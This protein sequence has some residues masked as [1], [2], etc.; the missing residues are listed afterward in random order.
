MAKHAV[1]TVLEQSG[2]RFDLCDIQIIAA[3]D[4]APE[5]FVCDAPAPCAIS[6]SHAAG[7]ALCEVTEAGHSPGCD[8]EVVEA[9]NRTFLA[10]YFVEEEASFVESLSPTARAV[11]ATLIWSAKESAL[12]SLREGLRRDTRS[13]IVRP[14]W[15][16][17][18]DGWHRFQVECTE[19]GRVFFGWWKVEGRLVVTIGSTS[20]ESV[21]HRLQA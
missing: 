5:V 11:G 3:P 16:G 17:P 20:A 7:V 12:K 18:E 9:G 21:P 6:I 4:G 2:P 14:R 15:D 19:T 10:D 13:V 1:R 8:I